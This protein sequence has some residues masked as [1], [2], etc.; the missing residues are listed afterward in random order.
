MEW[1]RLIA[2]LLFRLGRK[3]NVTDETETEEEK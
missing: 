1:K 3:M 2:V